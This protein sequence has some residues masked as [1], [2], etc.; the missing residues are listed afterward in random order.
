MP[1]SS[2]R[3]VRCVV[4]ADVDAR[5]AAGATTAGTVASPTPASAWTRPPSR[6][7]FEPFTQADESTTRRFGGSGLGL[8][9]CRELAELMG[10]HITRGKPAA[11]RFDLPL[12]ACRCKPGP[13]AGGR[14]AAAAA[15]PRAHPH[16]PPGA[17]R[18]PGAPR[19]RARADGTR[20]EDR[21]APLRA[22]DL[23]I[24]DAGSQPEY[25]ARADSHRG[26][27]GGR[28]WSSSPRQPKSRRR[29]SA[30]GWT[31]TASCSSP[32]SA[33]RC[34]EAL[35]AALDLAAGAASCRRVA[36]R[37]RRHRRPRAAGG[38]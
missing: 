15:A 8:A 34:I 14:A 16:A 13:A 26:G 17:G 4:K 11:G 33:M 28:D 32:C 5:D 21:S 27:P 23:L 24:V 3:R 30:A 20:R 29:I 19:S 37:P 18:V 31:A 38:G 36:G 6:K 12:S 35:A 25:A 1:S 2:P 10:G 22:Q 7:I 9:I